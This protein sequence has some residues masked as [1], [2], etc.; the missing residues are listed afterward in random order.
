MN[1]YHLI[2]RLSCMHILGIKPDKIYCLILQNCY[3]ISSDRCRLIP[4]HGITHLIFT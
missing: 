2:P 1:V 4:V 3:E